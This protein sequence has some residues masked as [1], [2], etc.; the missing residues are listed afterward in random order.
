MRF[1]VDR[2]AGSSQLNN[3]VIGRSTFRVDFRKLMAS[4]N[5]V[6]S[7][8]SQSYVTDFGYAESP[9]E[10][11]RT[12]VKNLMRNANFLFLVSAEK[13]RRE[14]GNGLDTSYKWTTTKILVL[15]TCWKAEKRKTS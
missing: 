14:G 6:G 11:F 7:R 12:H 9:A 1:E 8:N 10:R 3:I 5:Q 15:D 13:S 4:E 2:I